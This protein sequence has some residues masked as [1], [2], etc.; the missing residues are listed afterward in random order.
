MLL[1]NSKNATGVDTSNLA[2]EKYFVA[3]KV[4]V[5]KVYIEKLFNVLTD[6]DNIKTKS[7]RF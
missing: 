2:G 1:K 7:R 4:E 5:D 3:F 6:L